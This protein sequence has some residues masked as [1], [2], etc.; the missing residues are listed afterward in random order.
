[1][2]Q[3]AFKIIPVNTQSRSLGTLIKRLS[4]HMELSIYPKPYQL[5][6]SYKAEKTNIAVI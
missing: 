6:Y 3:Q 1:M 5:S 4:V 2:G